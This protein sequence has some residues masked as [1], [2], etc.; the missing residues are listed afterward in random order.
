VWGVSVRFEALR[1]TF[2]GCHLQIYINTST[3]MDAM[4]AA[5]IWD[6][7]AGLKIQDMDFVL[8]ANFGEEDVVR[9]CKRQERW[10]QQL[11]YEEYYGKLM[12]VSLRYANNEHDALDILHEAFIRIFQHIDRYQPG[13]SL[14]SWMR[15]IVVNTAIDFYRKR[16]RRRTE[17]LDHAAHISQEE[18]DAIS[19]CSEQEILLAV[20]QL[21]PTYR[22]IFNLFVVE[23]YSHKEIADLLDITESTSRSNLVKA[24]MKLKAMLTREITGNGY[25]EI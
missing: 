13:T 1:S 18:A 15:R 6:C 20:Q 9:A 4:F 16:M 10:A 11:L 14:L 25:E 8:P 3:F 12:V 19:H 24:R 7:L 23:G 5:R 21:S 17:E 2:S 22:T